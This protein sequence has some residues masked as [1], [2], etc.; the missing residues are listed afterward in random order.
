M[1]KKLELTKS[2]TALLL[3]DEVSLLMKRSTTV[4]TCD[5]KTL[6]DRGI[7][8]VTT[9]RFLWID[10]SHRNAVQLPLDS[11]ESAQL[12]TEGIFSRTTKIELRGLDARHKVRVGCASAIERLHEAIESSLR[13]REWTRWPTSEKGKTDVTS[14]SSSSSDSAGAAAGDESLTFNVSHAGIGG[15]VLKV[16]E[17][18]EER[19]QSLQAAFT[20]LDALMANARVMVDMA[21]RL[22]SQ[23]ASASSENAQ[24]RHYLMSVGIASPVTKKEAGSLYHSQLARQLSEFLDRPLRD[25]SGVMTLPDVYCLYNR[26]R[27]TELISPDDL[28]RACSLFESLQLPVALRSFDSGV[29]VVESKLHHSDE[30]ISQRL[31]QFYRESGPLSAF[32]VAQS[33]NIPMPLAL[34]QLYIAECLGVLARDESFEGLLF[35]ENMFI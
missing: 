10:S 16:K 27:G 31:V 14:A 2:G 26:A 28:F 23:D 11:V 32:D 15:I 20:D 30:A 29:V 34:E 7:A 12:V 9:H 17:R 22:S 4:Y 3:D 8:Q 24:F 18:A 6:Y 13:A 5:K 19:D 21:R 25:H 33:H 35:Y 1:F